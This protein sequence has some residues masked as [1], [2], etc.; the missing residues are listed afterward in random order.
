MMTFEQIAAESV[1]D[2]AIGNDAVTKE[3]NYVRA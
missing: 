1:L 2:M 3:N